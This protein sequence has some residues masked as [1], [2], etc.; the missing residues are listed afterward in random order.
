MVASSLNVV[1]GACKS[2]PS[3]INYPRQPTNSKLKDHAPK[4][5]TLNH[6][7]DLETLLNLTQELEASL[8]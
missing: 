2:P 6:E 5:E 7:M 3:L 1:R 8:A 4:K